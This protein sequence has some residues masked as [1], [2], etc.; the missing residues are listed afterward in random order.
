MTATDPGADRAESSARADADADP[1]DG[2]AETSTQR[3]DRN[4]NELLQEQRAV[5]TGTQILSGF[6]LA[7]AFQPRF[8]ELDAY[9][10]G[11]YLVLVVAA[12]MA[13]VLGLAPVTLHRALFGKHAKP[14][15]V[16]VANRLLVVQIGVVALIAAGVPGLIFDVALGRTAGL[17]ALGAGAGVVV[18][19]WLVVWR[20]G[21]RARQRGA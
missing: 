4:W 12:G 20:I 21:S 16:R 14:A 3:S 1:G 8:A 6:L 19:V 15:L 5:Q 9:A 13:T 2:R 17:V 7:V 18:V 10:T 11:L